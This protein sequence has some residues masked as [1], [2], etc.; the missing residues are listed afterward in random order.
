M[1]AVVQ[2]R[3]VEGRINQAN[4][5]QQRLRAWGSGRPVSEAPGNLFDQLWRKADV[6][7]KYNLYE[8]NHRENVEERM[9]L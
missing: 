6:D 5:V 7:M 4:S 2:A 3:G 8:V 9:M 1:T